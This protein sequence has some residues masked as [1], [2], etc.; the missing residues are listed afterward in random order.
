MTDLTARRELRAEASIAREHNAHM[1]QLA[2]ATGLATMIRGVNP[3]DFSTKDE[4]KAHL[5]AGI[6]RCQTRAANVPKIGR[7]A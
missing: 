4:Y 1:Q 6:E 3:A 7:V 5:I 2:L